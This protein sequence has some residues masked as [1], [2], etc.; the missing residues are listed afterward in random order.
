MVSTA[1]AFVCEEIL[2]GVHLSY[3]DE[4]MQ[5]L[6]TGLRMSVIVKE[7]NPTNMS[8][9]NGKVKFVKMLHQKFPKYDL[10]VTGTKL[11]NKET[12]VTNIA[13]SS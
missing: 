2:Q 5:I 6:E 10:Q 3:K 9:A 7:I 13:F 11:I 8:S 4:L 1:V 12:R